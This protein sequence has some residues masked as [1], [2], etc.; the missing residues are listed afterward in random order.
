M[1]F[2][3]A[4]L[5]VF[6]NAKSK[7]YYRPKLIVL[8]LFVMIF[9]FMPWFT[10]S[11][12]K[13]L[14]ASSFL[15]KTL[16]KYAVV[17]FFCVAALLIL[18][19]ASFILMIVLRP[20]VA[21]LSGIFEGFFEDI[22]MSSFGMILSFVIISNFSKTSWTQGFYEF[23]ISSP[24]IIQ[25]IIEVML[26]LNFVF[27]VYVGFV[28]LIDEYRDDHKPYSDDSFEPY[29]PPNRDREN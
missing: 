8:L 19:A 2:L 14:I 6:K 11:E 25:F 18:Q 15:M 1:D 12:A 5:D 17:I 27:S 4:V 20:V 9:T 28:W 24:L 16:D 3:N 29:M 10:S 26:G 22:A 13:Q 7:K 23:I 21:I